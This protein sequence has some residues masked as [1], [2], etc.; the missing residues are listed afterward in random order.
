MHLN[1]HTYFSLRYGTLS[2]GQL[3]DHAKKHGL[4]ELVLTDINNTSASIEFIR[5][6]K[7]AGIKPIVGIDF[8]N[9]A[10]Q[11]FIGIAKNNLGFLELNRFLSEHLCNK[12]P[13]PPIASDFKHSTVIYPLSKARN[14]LLKP[15]E[16]IGIQP[17]EVQ[18]LSYSSDR[19]LSKKMV[20]LSPFTFTGKTG[21]NIH[22][23]LRAIDN[24]T[25]LSKL[26]PAQKA[27]END[28]FIPTE[29]LLEAFNEFPEIIANTQQIIEQSHINFEFGT[30]KNK[31]LFKGS[32]AEDAAL[33][34]EET[35]NGMRYRFGDDNAEA[36]RRIEKELK[37]I[38]QL[39]FNAYF[40]IAWDIIRYAQSKGYDHVGRGSGANSIVAY[41]LRITDVDPIDLDL[42]FER[43]IN[44]FRS[45]PPD[46]DIDF[47][48]KN[49]DDITHYIFDKYGTGHTVLLATY[50]TFREK[51]ARREL[52]KVFGLPKEEIDR[53]DYTNRN[54]RPGDKVIDA[55]YRYA[56]LI[57][58]FPNYLSVHA[59][60]IL[61]SEKPIHY[62][63]AT[64]LP[65]KG[66]PITH[67]DMISAED[68]GL[69]KFDILS[70]RGL[71]HIRDCATIVKQNQGIDVDVHNIV[72]FKA[73]PKIR[74][75][76]RDGKT[77]GC[78]YVESPAMRMLLSKLKC[79]DY[80]TLVAASS[81]IRPGVARSGM[82]R[83]YIERF[84]NPNNYK[85]IHPKM[86][87]LMKETFGVMVYQE[88]VIKV[89]HHFAG[90][91]LAESDILRRGMSGKYRSRAEFTRLTDKF[92]S[93]CRKRG[94]PEKTTKEV[95]RQ[96]ESFAGYSFSK[97]HSASYAV[98]SYQ[99]L[100]L[101]AH[102]PKEFMVA[103]INNFG[104]FY[105]TEFYVHEAR[106]SGANIRHPDINLSDY[107]TCIKNADI[108]LGFIHIKSLERKVI[109]QLL[110]ERETSGPY[111]SFE[112]FIDRNPISL[113][114]LLIL[115]RVRAFDVFASNK[116]ELIVKANL[117]LQRRQ[118]PAGDHPPPP[119]LFV[120]PRKKWELPQ[121]YHHPIEDAYDDIELIGF[122][123]IN[124]FDLLVDKIEHRA[125]AR[126]LETYHRK[127]ILI[128]G[129]LVTIKNTI[130][131][132]KDRMQFGTFLDVSG[133]FFDTTHFPDTVKRW[134]FQGRGVYKIKGKVTSDFGFY[135]IEVMAI[136]K[137]P[138]KA[139]PR[140]D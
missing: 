80:K 54:Y 34:R 22:L 16:F 138:I 61:I 116:K 15:N 122:P 113:E 106:M 52:G 109:K 30:S 101:K 67:F 11:E 42:Y 137:M 85:V 10:Q 123:L 74:A 103:V 93:N 83:E 7:N 92:L 25:L 126:D 20:I 97:A 121:L 44:Q 91:T 68:I 135:S 139:D 75:L 114:Q 4:K 77:M 46:F 21:Y 48:W 90:L 32:K 79:E 128:Y 119:E 82:M 57:N 70:Q 136:R 110:N 84:H 29:K 26:H 65:P 36:K 33:L 55:V 9:N 131:I 140:Y 53:L 95:W 45:S 88:D 127:T 39:G 3:I 104:G 69:Y 112:D 118:V 100:F 63:T 73:D 66:F 108:Y 117:M 111:L 28:C 81:I 37:M 38:D 13:I 102:F 89:A 17:D 120:F 99:S 41:C 71:G 27:A 49:R 115:V 6:C 87:E 64:D 12:T 14:L 43:F 2:V 72:A 23:L 1:N 125:K 105:R 86:D 78:F 96:I 59:G 129:Y 76:I 94:Y 58:G 107:L 50:N 8:R 18:R 60:G 47:S 56:G 24:N 130:T 124:P 98:E 51:A 132:K 19:Y 5:Q 62:F 40:L 133:F 31:E 35:Y 134:P